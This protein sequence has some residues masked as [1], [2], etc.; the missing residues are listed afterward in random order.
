MH[1]WNPATQLTWV[2]GSQSEVYPRQKHETLSE[3]QTKMLKRARGMAQV[4]EK[5]IVCIQYGSTKSKM[6][7]FS[8]YLVKKH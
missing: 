4:L 6:K 2:G 3:K 7:V 8:F 5:N 1:I